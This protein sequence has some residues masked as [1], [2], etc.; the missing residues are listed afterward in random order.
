M[1]CRV[2]LSCQVFFIISLSSLRALGK[3][4]G[5]V[6]KR[7]FYGD[8][9]RNITC[10]GSSYDLRLPLRPDG[11]D[12]N[13]LTMQQLCAENIYGRADIPYRLGGWCSKVLE[14]AL[15]ESSWNGPTRWSQDDMFPTRT[16]V[17]FEFK[18]SRLARIVQRLSLSMAATQTIGRLSQSLFLQLGVR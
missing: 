2:V 18:M 5:H 10:L 12:L 14:P 15:L 9:R 16:G 13:Q 3:P 11:V 1:A 4:S 7:T 17:S 8:P 6:E